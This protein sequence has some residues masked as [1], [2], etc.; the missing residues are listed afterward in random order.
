M[1]TFGQALRGYRLGFRW[2]DRW[3][4]FIRIDA[5]GPP[6]RIDL[7]P[8]GLLPSRKIGSG[9]HRAFW[10]GGVKRAEEILMMSPKVAAIKRVKQP[11]TLFLDDDGQ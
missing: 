11:V 5:Q 10:D 2:M 4:A 8:A 7:Y 1:I 3:Q 6:W 9:E